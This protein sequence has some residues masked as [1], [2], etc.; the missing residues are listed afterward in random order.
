MAHWLM[1]CA[2]SSTLRRAS[3]DASDAARIAT[4]EEHQRCEESDR[5]FIS[6]GRRWKEYH[7]RYAPPLETWPT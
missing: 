2:G 6:K 5:C 3:A 7:C 4:E 1:S